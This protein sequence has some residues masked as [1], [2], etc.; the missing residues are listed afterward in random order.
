MPGPGTAKV[1]APNQKGF[2][3]V[4][5][6]AVMAIL[7]ILSGLVAGAVTG[8][9]NRGQQ[10][11]LDGDRDSVQKAANAF[12]LESFP[13]K[14]PVVGLD[15][16]PLDLVVS[17]DLGIRLIDLKAPLPQDPTKTFVPSFLTNLPESSALVSWRIDTR[18][19][20]AFFANDGAPLIKP[21]SNELNVTASET[22]LSAPSDHT[23]ELLMGKNE[24][25]LETLV[26]DIPAGYSIGGTSA[27]RGTLVGVLN[28]TLDADNKAAS[29]QKIH[30]GG[31]IV[32]SGEAGKW[33]LV[34]DYND[35]IST[36]DDVD[37][38]VK[39]SDEAVRVHE[40]SI[41]TP[42]SSSGGNLTLEMSRGS[43]PDQNQ[44]T[45]TWALTIFGD[46]LQDV[47]P[48]IAIPPSS[49]AS[50][51]GLQASAR[52]LDTTDGYQVKLPSKAGG[53]GILLVP[54]L[55][56]ITNPS[57]R[58][59][60]RWNAE[61][62]TSIDVVVGDTAFFHDVPGSQGV[63]IKGEFTV[64]QPPPNP[65]PVVPPESSFF[66]NNG[67]KI[68]DNLDALMAS[69]DPATDLGIIVLFNQPP[70]SALLASVGLTV[71]PR[72][73]F[74]FANGI[75]TDLNPVEIEALALEAVV[76]RIE[77]DDSVQVP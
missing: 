61:E 11:R 71:D 51:G 30:F 47:T 54:T 58:G 4:E 2:T 42:S 1:I 37:A 48:V 19:G 39:P 59:V 34:V 40:I 69:T 70:T 43:D 10:T 31:A 16:T 17:P 8:L 50:F 76:V 18:S 32:S 33:L 53:T 41:S 24:A 72:A 26:V 27:P 15:D 68:N 25:A 73:T 14:L 65:T 21:S 63:L 38:E 28:A 62:N 75:A 29:G 13:Q 66:D 56:I 20:Q 52:S 22:A 35:N 5:L 49:T 77:N 44:A 74:E 7:G 57:T 23:L 12:S 46:A 67:N 6:L 3:L 55:R 36:S 64:S 60:K 45:E 9:G